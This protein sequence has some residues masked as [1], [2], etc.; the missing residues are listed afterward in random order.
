MANDIN[1]TPDMI[2]NFVDMLKNN[3]NTDNS[4]NNSNT[5][6]NDNPSNNINL[7]EILSKFSL[8]NNSSENNNQNN[9]SSPIDFDTII[10]IKSIMETLNTKDDPKSNLLYSLKPY[11]RKSKQAKLDQYVNLMK[12]SQV[13]NLFKNEKEK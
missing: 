9:S 11:L 5:D 10:K 4:K 1:I 8:N 12:I 13:T 6:N 7:D 3:Q 2:N